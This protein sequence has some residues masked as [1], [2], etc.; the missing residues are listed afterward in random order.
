MQVAFATRPASPAEPNEDFI[1]ATPHSI[2]VLDGAGVPPGMETGC[3]H[4]TTWF[5]TQLGAALLHRSFTRPDWSLAD[6]LADAIDEVAGLH[7]DGCDLAHP[8]TPSATVAML[9]E[10]ADAV[11]H[12]VLADSTIVLDR[13]GAIETI[14]DNRIA[15]VARAERAA[16]QQW[17]TGAGPHYIEPISQ[18]VST[19]REHRNRPGGFWVASTDPTA[20]HEAIVGSTPRDQLRRAAVMTD[21]AAQLVDDF[22]LVT[23]PEVLSVLERQGPSAL[24]DR[25]RGAEDSDPDRK[26]WRRSKQH[27][28][29]T[30]AICRFK[31]QL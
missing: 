13:A 16:L 14:C 7:A 24:I 27:D 4:G 6:T 20:A 8:G 28:D 5:V 29:A 11:E 3:V 23:W 15:H 12:L 21:G 18:L 22:H 9:R 1:G 10:R 17:P 2:V 25:V 26:R 31:P 30:V 19:Q